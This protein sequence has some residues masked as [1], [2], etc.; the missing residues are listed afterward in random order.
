MSMFQAGL[1]PNWWQ[2][3]KDNQTKVNSKQ[4]IDRQSPTVEQWVGPFQLG[5]SELSRSSLEI[6]VNYLICIASGA[7][8]NKLDQW[9]GGKFWNK[10]SGQT[11]SHHKPGP[12]LSRLQTNL[13]PNQPSLAQT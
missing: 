9:R 10:W 13:T 6:E 3:A 5:P 8:R 2:L 1:P 11:D 4:I 7:G 12:Y